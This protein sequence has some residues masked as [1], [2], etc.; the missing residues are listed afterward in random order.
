MHT[1]ETESNER[2]PAFRLDVPVHSLLTQPG[3]LIVRTD[4]TLAPCFPMYS[5]TY[6]WGTIENHKFET[7]QLTEMKKSCQPHCFSTLNHILAYCYNDAR[8]I[9]SMFRQALNRFQGTTNFD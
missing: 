4:G 8:V 9:K 6:D 1:V 5:A 3:S 2:S 7:K